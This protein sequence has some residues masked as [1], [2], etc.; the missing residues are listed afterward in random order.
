[1]YKRQSLKRDGSVEILLYHT[2]TTEAFQ[3]DTRTQD[4]SRNVVAVG[5]KIA[6]ELEAA[7]LGVVHDLSLI[8]IFCP[9]LTA[10]RAVACRLSL[11]CLF[12]FL[13]QIVERGG[14]KELSQSYVQ[15]VAQLFD[16]KD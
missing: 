8:H 3:G 4:N 16:R 5:E 14:G 9:R 13:F 15:P 6:A 11:A 12:D 2:H 1:M 10:A 7:G